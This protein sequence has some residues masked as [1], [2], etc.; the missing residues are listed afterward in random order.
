M[1]ERQ[2]IAVAAE[3]KKAALDK[4]VRAANRWYLGQRLLDV[5]MALLVAACVLI[6]YFGYFYLAVGLLCMVL[7]Y[8]WL[9]WRHWNDQ[10]ISS[11][12]VGVLDVDDTSP[13]EHW[14]DATNAESHDS[15]HCDSGGADGDGGGGD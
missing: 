4:K 11:G 14:S 9:R 8:A 15:S 2:K 10:K 3:E 6:R 12:E 5:L 1:G 7:L 13:T